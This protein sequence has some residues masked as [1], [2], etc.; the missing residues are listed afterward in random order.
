V[1]LIVTEALREENP[2]W[3][4]EAEALDEEAMK[5]S[6]QLSTRTPENIYFHFDFASR[7]NQQPREKYI[8]PKK[9]FEV[10]IFIVIVE[11]KEKR[12]KTV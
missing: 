8:S 11:K 2:C 1:Y 9:N 3:A 7:M 4:R 6:T 5:G 10:F 12:K